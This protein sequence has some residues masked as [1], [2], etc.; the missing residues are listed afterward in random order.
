MVVFPNAKINL[1]L[2]VKGKRDD[3]FHNIE[4]IMV[5]VAFCDILEIVPSRDKQTLLTLSGLPVRGNP[6][7]NIVLKAF[8]L[9][10]GLAGLPPVRIH[11]HKVIPSEAGLGGGSSD[12]AF[13]LKMLNDLFELG[14]D[15]TILARNALKLGSDCPFFLENKPQYAVGRGEV[16]IPS[17]IALGGKNIAI[18]KPPVS[19]STAEAYAHVRIR[20]MSAFLPECI[21]TDVKHWK[22]CVLNDFEEYAFTRYPVIGEIKMKLYALGAE[23][24]LMSGSGSAVYGIFRDEVNLMGIFPGCSI[25]TGK[26]LNT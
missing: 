4:T 7:E 24:A 9:L 3:G 23:F 5:P 19:V 10:E 25:W 13:T 11:L 14:L 2:H 20:K 21:K 12:G 6:Q 16:L 22:E 17:D 1:G 15:D 8:R 26:T 18:V